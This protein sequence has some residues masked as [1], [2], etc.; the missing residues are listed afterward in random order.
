MHETEEQNFGN[1]V[2]LIRT[3]TRNG[4]QCFGRME[5]TAIRDIKPTTPILLESNGAREFPLDS[6]IAKSKIN[7]SSVRNRLTVIPT[8]M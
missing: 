3:Y 4:V 1:V 7:Q 6:Y 2:I 5:L 8:A